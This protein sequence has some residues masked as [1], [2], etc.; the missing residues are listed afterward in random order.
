MKNSPEEKN[1]L[2]FPTIIEGGEAINLVPDFCKAMGDARLLP[3]ITKEYMEEKIKE[4]LDKLDV[5]YKLRTIIYVPACVIDENEKIVKIVEKNAE[6]FLGTTPKKEGAGP[7][8][9]LWMFVSRGI[10]AINFGPDGENMHGP[11]EFVYL[12]SMI[13]VTK[14]FAV[15]AIEFL[16]RDL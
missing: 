14:I 9:D 16:S 11:D 8:S 7:W 4:I 3:G 6:S 10:P 5:N 12:D 1:V 13:K 15:S 2:T